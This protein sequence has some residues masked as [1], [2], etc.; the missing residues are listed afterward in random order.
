MAGGPVIMKRAVNSQGFTL[1]EVMVALLVLLIGTMGVMGLQYYAV[2]GNAFS[3]EIR[4]STGM[5]QDMI[6]RIKEIPYASIAAGTDVMTVEPSYS[7]NVAFTR[8]W[9]TAPN[10]LGF[11]LAGDDESCNAA[12]A[13]NPCASVPDAALVVPVTAIKVRTCWTDKS[14]V[15]HSVTMETMRWDENVTP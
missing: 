6:E 2:T 8:R 9:W 14:G 10:C 11:S 4:T 13:P 3:R 12:L 7:G 15:V 1:I 5:T